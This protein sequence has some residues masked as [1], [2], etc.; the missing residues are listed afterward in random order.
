MILTNIS[1]NCHRI[2]NLKNIRVKFCIVTLLCAYSGAFIWT[3]VHQHARGN[4][5][6]VTDNAVSNPMKRFILL[7]TFIRDTGTAESSWHLCE[8]ECVC[9]ICS[10]IIHK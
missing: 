9:V 4:A 2:H 5:N 3:F 7:S 10:E 8:C 6:T 1:I